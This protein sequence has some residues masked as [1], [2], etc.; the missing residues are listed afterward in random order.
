LKTNITV[1]RDLRPATALALLTFVSLA[2]I[3]GPADARSCGMMRGPMAYNWAPMPYPMMRQGMRGPAQSGGGYGVGMK[4]GPSVVAITRGAGEFDTLLTALDAAGLTGLLEGDG[5]Y[6]LFAPTDA[7]FKKLPP[8]ALQELLGDKTKLIAL[9]K[10]H[11]VPGRVSAAEILESQEL[12]TA[13]GQPL[14]TQDLSVIRAD[15][16][17]RNGVIQV[18]DTVLLPKG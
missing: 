3:G 2:V 1:A 10:Y 12:K 11:V 9:L 13:S 8:G 18:V 7:A 4:V 5:P 15:I 14:Q 17:A 16:P 6:T